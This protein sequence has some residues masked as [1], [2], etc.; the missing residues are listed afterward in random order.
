[1]IQLMNTVIIQRGS[2][3]NFPSRSR[4]SLKDPSPSFPSSFSPRPSSYPAFFQ[5][6]SVGL[7][8]PSTT[9]EHATRAEGVFVALPFSHNG[10]FRKYGL[11]LRTRSTT[12]C[13]R[14]GYCKRSRR[15][16]KKVC[17]GLTLNS[18]VSRTLFLK[19][20]AFLR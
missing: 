10:F 9:R 11:D 3:T 1:M 17:N 8:S 7:Q 4:P 19:M 18:R 15:P 13:R 5:L 20:Q 12:S 14:S 16:R 6:G 2:T